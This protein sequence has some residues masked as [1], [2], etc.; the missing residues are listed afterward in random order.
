MT[1]YE[2]NREKKL[3]YQ[4]EYRRK[5]KEK[6][7]LYQEAYYRKRK[8]ADPSYTKQGKPRIRPKKV[9]VKEVKQVKPKL[10]PE[11]RR[12]KYEFNEASFIVSLD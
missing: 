8:E 6:V 7:A 9:R 3:A 2:E 4:E 12:S 10:F 1:Y 5:N 11:P